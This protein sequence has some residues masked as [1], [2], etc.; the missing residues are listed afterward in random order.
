MKA[1]SSELSLVLLDM[2]MPEMSGA[3]TYER[4]R[5]LAP[6]LKVLL[7]SGF[8]ADGQARALLELGC[9]DF[10]QKPFDLAQL[11]AKIRRLL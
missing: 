7:T 9:S 8:S 2:T 4:I 11:S 3:R 10:I 6:D 1:R 5:E